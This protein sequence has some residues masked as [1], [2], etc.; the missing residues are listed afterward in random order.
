MQYS[1]AISAALVYE[2][3]RQLL[4]GIKIRCEEIQIFES[5]ILTSHAMK[6]CRVDSAGQISVGTDLNSNA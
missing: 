4:V 1:L 5:N 3:F 2:C 6:M